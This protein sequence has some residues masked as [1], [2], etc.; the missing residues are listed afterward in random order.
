[1]FHFIWVNIIDNHFVFMS[2]FKIIDYNMPF[3][4]RP[5]KYF[6]SVLDY[7]VVCPL[8]SFLFMLLTSS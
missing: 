3:D 8:C 6:S 4:S 2:E 5:K 7:F 1:M